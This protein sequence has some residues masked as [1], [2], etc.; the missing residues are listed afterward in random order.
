MTKVVVEYG[1]SDA[2]RGGRERCCHQR[3]HGRKPWREVIASYEHV[4]ALRLEPASPLRPLG[5]R[6]GTVQPTTKSKWSSPRHSHLPPEFG[7]STGRGRSRRSGVER[8][9]VVGAILFD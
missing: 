8:E 1:A 9:H 3:R 4:I 7:W 6:C 2:Q 5:S